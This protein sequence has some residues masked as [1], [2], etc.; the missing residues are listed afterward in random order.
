MITEDLPPRAEPNLLPCSSITCSAAQFLLSWIPLY[1]LGKCTLLLLLLAPDLQ[2]AAAVFQRAVIPGIQTL[3]HSINHIVMPNLI[4]I[5]A[6]LPWRLL[7]VIF[8]AAA[9][10]ESA[11]E[12]QFSLEDSDADSDVSFSE[13]EVVRGLSSLRGL[14]SPCTRSRHI[15]SAKKMHQFASLHSLSNPPPV[16]VTTQL[17]RSRTR[18]G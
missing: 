16:R 8:P 7:L 14:A 11:A 12:I 1:H 5:V 3:H 15:A 2:I 4:E 6:T 18:G 10:E 13:A 17:V 9:S